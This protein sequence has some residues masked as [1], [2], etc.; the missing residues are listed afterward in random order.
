M[1]DSITP[2]LKFYKVLMFER[3]GIF[4]VPETV[5]RSVLYIDNVLMF[6]FNV[7]CIFISSNY[8]VAK[9]TI[10]LSILAENLLA[11]GFNE[12]FPEAND[13]SVQE[14]ALASGSQSKVLN[15]GKTHVSIVGYIL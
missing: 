10:V 3:L 2:L 1:C 7:L 4:G 6:A 13:S 9:D 5:H 11:L 12:N 15:Q 14:R 8:S